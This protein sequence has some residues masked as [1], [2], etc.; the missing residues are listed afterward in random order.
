MASE[1]NPQAQTSLQHH[2]RSQLYGIDIS[3]TV[4][5]VI[6]VA[7]R[8]WARCRSAGSHGWDDWLVLLAL[9]ALFVS[10]GMNVISETTLQSHPNAHTLTL[11]VVENGLGLRA[12]YVSLQQT[13]TI[14]KALFVETLNYLILLCLVKLAIIVLY[15]RVFPLRGFRITSWILGT[16]IVIWTVMFVL[17]CKLA[18]GLNR[19]KTF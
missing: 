3:F 8:F 15:C 18:H 4:L 9:C 13:I 16:G 2:I 10:L 11:T 5:A 6:A 14:G 12:E 7:L 1:P 19:F 17:L